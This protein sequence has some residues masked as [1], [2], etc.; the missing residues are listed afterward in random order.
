MNTDFVNALAR[1]QQKM[2]T[3]PTTAGTRLQPR[4][5][6]K[7][8]DITSLITE[9]NTKFG[10]IKGPETLDIILE[11]HTRKFPL[12]IVA[13]PE[14]RKDKGP[15][16]PAITNIVKI[17]DDG[18]AK[19][20]FYGVGYWATLY[21]TDFAAANCT[22]ETYIG[23]PADKME[24]QIKLTLKFM[25][26]VLDAGTAENLVQSIADTI[27]VNKIKK[28]FEANPIKTGLV[29]EKKEQLKEVFSITGLR[30]NP[31]LADKSL[32]DP[33]AFKARLVT[34]NIYFSILDEYV[35]NIWVSA[36]QT[37]KDNISKLMDKF[38]TDYFVIPP[39]LSMKRARAAIWPKIAGITTR[40][41]GEG[42]ERRMRPSTL[43][44][45]LNK[46]EAIQTKAVVDEKVVNTKLFSEIKTSQNWDWLALQ[47]KKSADDLKKMYA[48]KMTD[49]V[50]HGTQK[51]QL[52]D[53]DWYN[54]DG[55]YYKINT[56]AISGV[57]TLDE[58][59]ATK[60]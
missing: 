36:N 47:S 2:S 35:K 59:L 49:G 40:L 41:L 43:G 16:N 60:K 17:L 38:I 46:I 15:K 56:D 34:E 24:A 19:P 9:F 53:A 55:M 3:T 12:Y 32:K 23:S 28:H 10:A 39:T 44:K 50:I 14:L 30:Y 22:E 37:I 26:D 8:V 7:K 57:V 29:K 52:V 51:K 18:N 13:K 58:T 31:E 42:G 54:F 48:I 33:S 6:K 27:T 5:Q 4:G 25:E 20:Q 1:H 45:A 11:T 21:A